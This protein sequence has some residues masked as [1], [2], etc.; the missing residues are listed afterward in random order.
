ML[1]YEKKAKDKGFSFIIGVDEVGRGPLAGPVVAAAVRLKQTKFHNYIN[2]SKKLSSLQRERAYLEIFQKS[3]VGIGI[4][5][6]SIIDAINILNATK[7]AMERAIT[8]LIYS[9]KRK[10]NKNKVILLLDGNLSL[11][12]PFHSK[13]IIGGDGKSLSIAAASI[14]AK[15]TR[16]R[17]MSIYDK[18]YPKY[19]F[20][21]H[22]G[23]G[24]KEHFR[25]IKKHGSCSIH[26]M[27]FYPLSEI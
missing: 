11:S 26:R 24:T 23:Y 7:L 27:S 10:I 18:I 2:D 8:N 13:S 4:I 9:S 14:V 12:L 3:I 19:R 20:L 6:E 21:T 16:D 25:A 22:K 5:N 1:Y 17:I 15:V